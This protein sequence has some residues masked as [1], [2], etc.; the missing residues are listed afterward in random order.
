MLKLFLNFRSLLLSQSELRR[1]RRILGS[2]VEIGRSP[3]IVDRAT[4]GLVGT[5]S[6]VHDAGIP[7]WMLFVLRWAPAFLT[8]FPNCKVLFVSLKFVCES[9]DD[10]RQMCN[11]TLPQS[12]KFD[13]KSFGILSFFG[14]SGQPKTMC[15]R[16][17]VVL[18][19][20]N[21]VY[22]FL[23]SMA[24][25]RQSICIMAMVEICAFFFGGQSASNST[26][27]SMILKDISISSHQ[28]YGSY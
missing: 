25:P 11:F 14:A 6:M 27:T 3:K 24:C 8:L 2:I 16:G 22:F 23:T 1:W 21:A 4:I 9:V 10:Y 7:S 13:N 28:T 5:M 19:G 26:I 20:L 12:E 15:E 17:Y 18:I